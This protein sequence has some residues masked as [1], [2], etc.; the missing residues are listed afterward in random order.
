MDEITLINILNTLSK[1]NPRLNWAL[2]C[3]YSNGMDQSFME[4]KVIDR[5]LDRL[6]SSKIRGKILFD[7]DSGE[8]VKVIYHGLSKPRMP[9]QITD[10]LLDILSLERRNAL[11][12]EN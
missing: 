10:M 11:P 6:N 2:N 5:Y 4:I 7:M 3:A 1:Y 8:V 9:L 12:L